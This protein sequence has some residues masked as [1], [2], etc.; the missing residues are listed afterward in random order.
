MC[1]KSK[2]TTFSYYKKLKTEKK[3]SWTGGR[4]LGPCWAWAG[5]QDVDSWCGDT[6]AQRIQV[7]EMM[8][9]MIIKFHDQQMMMA[10]IL[11][12]KKIQTDLPMNII[13]RAA[14]SNIL[15]GKNLTAQK[16]SVEKALWCNFCVGLR[17]K[18]I[19]FE[20]LLPSPGTSINRV[21]G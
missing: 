14:L 10:E 20:R 6:Q 5:R 15:W 11:N 2:S 19:N 3:W 13:F 4:W 17:R 12:L 1:E 9:L 18:R 16:K 21:R 8:V 7:A